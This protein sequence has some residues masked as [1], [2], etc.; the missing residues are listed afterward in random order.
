[1]NAFIINSRGRQ[2]SLMS[3]GY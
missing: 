1:M 3:C 2:T